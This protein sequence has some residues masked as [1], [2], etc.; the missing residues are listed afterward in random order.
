MPS[1]PE[2]P[3][4]SAPLC[5][6]PK[7]YVFE[8]KNGTGVAFVGSSNLSESALLTG[9]EWNYRVVAKTETAAFPGDPLGFRQPVRSPGRSRSPPKSIVIA[10]SGR[11]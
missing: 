10:D 2:H 7:A 1:G 8:R 11:R 4:P 6:H 9:I 3:G 5:F